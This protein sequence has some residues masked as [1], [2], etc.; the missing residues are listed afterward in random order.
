MFGRLGSAVL[1]VG[2]AI[3]L[4]VLAPQRTLAQKGG[5]QPGTPPTDGINIVFDTVPPSAY[6]DPGGGTFTTSAVAV[7]IYWND[8]IKLQ[9]AS[10]LITLNGVNVAAGFTYSGTFTSAT[11][12]GTITLAYGA[13]TLS[14]SICDQGGN[15]SY[16]GTATY[17]LSAPD[18]TPPTV[19]LS[20]ATG[21]TTY[22]TSTAV[23]VSWGDNQLLNPASAVVT[24]N[25]SPASLTYSGSSTSATS[26][27]YL[28]LVGGNNALSARICDQAGNCTT[29]TATYT[30]L[31]YPPTIS[32][33]S[34]TRS[35]SYLPITINWTDDIGLNDASR[36]ITFNGANVTTGAGFNYGIDPNSMDPNAHLS[37]G[38]V[39]LQPG[40]NVLAAYICDTDG[41]CTTQNWSYDYDASPPS[42]T[43]S[44]G[45]YKNVAAQQIT[46]GYCDDVGLNS[47]TR[48]VYVT[49][50]SQPDW[51]VNYSFPYTAV[52]GGGCAGAAGQ[53]SGQVDLNPGQND[54]HS[55]ICDTSGNCT[56][57]YTNFILDQSLPGVTFSTAS[58]GVYGSASQTFTTNLSDNEW[59]DTSTWL[60]TLNGANVTGSFPYATNGRTLGSATGAV[61]L[62]PGSNTLT[63][64]IC[65]LAGNCNTQSATYTYDNTPPFIA[66]TPS[67]G[68]GFTSFSQSFT[69]TWSDNQA[70]N[71][72]SR[73]ITLNG[74]AVTASFG[75][76]GGGPA[77]SSASTVPMTLVSGT[78]TLTARIC[79]NVGNCA[80]QS[81]TYT[82]DN[83]PPTVAV[84]PASGGSYAAAAL[85]VTI[86]WHDNLGLNAGSRTVTL[87]GAD[88]SAVVGFTS[89]S[90]TDATSA[91]RLT[92]AANTTN[93]FVARICD[94][95]GNCTSRT[96]TYVY[97]AAPPTVAFLPALGKTFTARVVTDTVTWGDNLNLNAASVIIT[98]NGNVATTFVYSGS[99]TSAKSVGTLTLAVGSNAVTA[100]ICDAAGNCTTSSGTYTFTPVPPTIAFAPG[101]RSGATQPMTVNWGDDVGLDQP[102]HTL[103]FN[104]ASVTTPF[105]FTFTTPLKAATSS[106]SLTLVQGLNTLA[107]YICDTDGAC[108]PKSWTYTYDG[109][110]PTIAFAAT[111]AY[112]NLATRL[113][114]ID[115]C[116]NIGLDTASR[117]VYLTLAA[118]PT[119]RT[120]FRT[121][122]GYTAA[123]RA[124]CG[125]AGTS[126]GTVS[127]SPGR[128]DIHA[129]ICDAQP[130]CIDKI[131]S[132]IRDQVL[133]GV[134]VSPAS[135]LRAAK[136]VSTTITWTDNEALD[137]PTRTVTMNGTSV[138]ASLNFT[139]T[140][141]K[142]A[143]SV[144]PLPL[145]SG[146]NTLVARICDLAANCFAR[147]V[148]YSV[149]YKVAVTPP[150]PPTVEPFAVTTQNF[151]VKNTGA[152]LSTYTL[153]VAC[154]TQV[155]ASCTAPAT[156][157]LDS[158]LTTTVAV[159][160]RTRFGGPASTR[161]F[162]TATGGAGTLLGTSTAN[163]N[164]NV[165]S[166]AVALS[167]QVTRST[168][169]PGST[170]TQKFAIRNL[171][172]VSGT[173]SF[174]VTCP[175]ALVPCTTPAAKTVAAGA[176]DTVVVSYKGGAH[177]TRA[178]VGLAASYAPDSS[179]RGSASV[180]VSVRDPSLLW[181]EIAGVNPG[182]TVERALCLS[183]S[184]GAGAASECGDLRLVHALPAVQSMM[185]S[186]SPTLL[187]NSQHIETRRWVY[188]DVT[189][190]ATTPQTV[191]A[192]VKVAGATRGTG[193]WTGTEWG[194]SRT[195]RIAVPVNVAG[196]ST[197]VLDYDIDV[198][199]VTAGVQASITTTSE[200]IVVG[201]TQSSFGAGWWVAGLEQL[202]LLANGDKLWVGGDGSARR[203][204]TVTSGA[205][206]MADPI[207]RI[208]SLTYDAAT[209]YVRRLP[210]NLRVKF[211]V[212]GKHVAT[213]NRLGQ[214]TRFRYDGNGRLQYI[215][216]APWTCPAGVSV[217]PA[218]CTALGQTPT[219]AFTYAF[220]YNATTGMLASVT[221]PGALA[222]RVTNVSIDASRRV[223]T[224]TDPDLKAVRFGFTSASALRVGM[225]VNRRAD[226]TKYAFDSTYKV[227]SFTAYMRGSNPNVTTTV[228]AAE[229]LGRLGGGLPSSVDTASVYTLID[230]PRTD[231]VDTTRI[232]IDRF[233]APRKV[234]NALGK[235]TLITRANSAFPALVTA[236]QQP[237]GFTTQAHYDWR[238]H[239]DTTT[240]I[241]PYGGVDA[242][243]TYAWD[244]KWDMLYSESQPDGHL[245]RIGYDSMNG[246]RLWQEDGRGATSRVNFRYYS[247]GAAN[248]LLMAVELPGG[249]GADS[250]AYSALA[251][252]SLV[253]T[254]KGY[255]TLQEQDAIGQTTVVKQQL[256]SGNVALWH[257]D[258]TAYDTVGQVKHEVSYGPRR[259]F[260]TGGQPDST[261]DQQVVIDHTRN[262]E[263]SDS[264]LVRR[265]L[266]DDSN[267]GLMTTQ[268]VYDALGR[269]TAEVA[270]DGAR[271]STVYDLAGNALRRLTRRND[272]VSGVRLEVTMTY[273]ALNRLSTRLTPQVKYPD[274]T[275]GIALRNANLNLASSSAG[276]NPSYPRYK[277][278][279][280][281][282]LTIPS[283]LAVFTYDAMGNMLTAN[284]GDAKITRTYHPNGQLWTDLLSTRTVADTLSAGGGFSLHQYA[285]S[286][287]YDLNGR[288]TAIKHPSQL[289]NGATADSAYYKY[290]ALTGAL[291]RVVDI[292]G[293]VTRYQFNG[294]NELAQVYLADHSVDNFGY[295]ADGNL[296]SHITIDGPNMFRNVTIRTDARGKMTSLTNTAGAKENVTLAYSGLGHLAR[297]ST[298]ATGADGTIE[299]Q[300]QTNQWYTYDALANLR[301]QYT[302]TTRSRAGSPVDTR[303]SIFKRFQKFAAGTG[304]YASST[305]S[306]YQRDTAKYDAAGNTE[307]STQSW[308]DPYSMASPAD[309]ASY[310]AADG[311]LYAADYRAVSPGMTVTD[312]KTVFE[313]YRYDALGRRV[314]LRS[315][316]FCE[317]SVSYFEECR[318][319]YVR[320]TVWDGDAE[321]YEIQMPADTNTVADTMENDTAPVVRALGVNRFDGNRLFGR[322]AY[323]YGLGIDKPVTIVRF[324]Y[325]DATDTVDNSRTWKEF[326]TFTIVPLWNVRGSAE[327]G[328]FVAAG[329][330]Q[331]VGGLCLQT[332][333]ARC[334]RAKFDGFYEVYGP[335]ASI[336]DVVFHGSLLND[337]LDKAGTQYRRNRVYDPKT[338]AFTQE[339]PIGL[340]GGTNL[341]GFAAGDPVNFSDPFGLCPVTATD[342]VPCSATYGAAFGAI[343]AG[344][345][346]LAAGG[347]TV[348][349]GGICLA[350]APAIIGGGAALGALAGGAIGHAIDV[351]YRD[352]DPEGAS[353]GE[354][355]GKGFTP[356]GK[357]EVRGPEG[358]PCTYCKGPTTRK[359]GPTQ[360]QGEHVIPR[361]DGGN[362]SPDNGVNACRTC[363]LDKGRRSPSQWE[364]RWYDPK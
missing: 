10:R 1:M 34:G 308:V 349:S 213:V 357:D 156:V 142:N 128:N 46:I 245:V 138:L 191:T 274:R 313:E 140:D 74:T 167:P 210:N 11:S 312:W 327:T 158:G 211:D 169:L 61:T 100:K 196:D 168:V 176:V 44:G 277:G 139:S 9:P 23:T 207:D 85:D 208:D 153:T 73:S 284:N 27:G 126:S 68:T 185:K 279:G 262:A 221:S 119:V 193:T 198:V 40:H 51:R 12:T 268:W 30:R 294:R 108:T 56:D 162:L 215:D 87:N 282:G 275:E 159:T 203:Y 330:T 180:D 322:V 172:T 13:N 86:A 157:T 205:L 82:A 295:D 143:T 96:S 58:G 355:A 307:F 223:T 278:P 178:R 102:S 188:A 181:A 123:T 270:P 111:P 337:K 317:Q 5:K 329:A 148:T 25:G 234:H 233:G 218:P 97:D 152:A 8:D 272:P 33:T 72:A 201:R 206:W 77:A 125:G 171:G 122:F 232:W 151:T 344:L 217:S 150:A 361:A 260:T 248:G 106:G 264:V 358:S 266:P 147:T 101:T 75:Y 88:V 225:R 326:P 339:D 336:P 121:A 261:P 353:D 7:T 200:L 281:V 354:R 227:R 195:R 94:N 21:L 80:T 91:G 212:T 323:A 174:A 160:I 164:V 129:H 237:N 244:A 256:D 342:P 362:G 222:T 78:N 70:L 334:V 359:P 247:G 15:C 109:V 325:A 305:D 132:I 36:T 267:L 118:T 331:G 356:G 14:A 20:P 363:N 79:D 170:T 243:T 115:W 146:L 304:R 22:S 42:I 19:A 258:S 288:R 324:R 286:Y 204:R 228:T 90:A 214:E 318:V 66:L 246:N 104:G 136:T 55:R 253:Q 48:E 347:C 99:A 103:T 190:P 202:T 240:A 41:A 183:I 289:A 287:G 310:Y 16:P 43:F 314:W 165:K 291:E 320:R 65:D 127:L 273:D 114:S 89:S 28:A 182:A 306:A 303:T 276:Q 251:N 250:M 69:V 293:N 144:G 346:V 95:V 62:A 283:D 259:L 84:T 107:G 141:A 45:G 316:R 133:P 265:A 49:M 285:L 239:V 4:T 348:G 184:L 17:T 319:S 301:Y 57:Q 226:S 26:S 302:S 29:Q 134:A 199:T 163:V 300:Q 54:V 333:G 186:R 124:G 149:A 192:T 328:L 64:R 112:T 37:S 352:G 224:I 345:G 350:G 50:P 137:G 98:L 67:S 116:D 254:A 117:D 290:D 340:A 219:P 269:V 175:A 315:R 35:G 161:V 197:N 341:Y 230:G 71:A 76:T 63:A 53:A 229:A 83:S 235:E 154:D 255:Q 321:L 189:V 257:V 31:L 309:R 52:S 238:G 166:Y 231:V 113:F 47:A 311:K 298:V 292:M 135:G 241:S 296:A 105:G 299:Y 18:A 179:A 92:L 351:L 187:Y 194:T 209:G 120:S 81:A 364:P 24:L 131:V 2:A 110:L 38:S 236:Q 252:L 360:S 173:Y 242:I 271:D 177:G 263:G 297:N 130:N 39:N 59:L 6:V 3:L 280:G 145:V 332:D 338:G 343:G 155:L 32:V 93:T 335:M 220:A 60:V 216:V 249:T